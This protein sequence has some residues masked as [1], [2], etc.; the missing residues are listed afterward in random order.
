MLQKISLREAESRAFKATYQDG[1]WDIYLGLMFL[2]LPL[3]AFLESRGFYRSFEFMGEPLARM[4]L[5][6]A[7]LLVV[8]GLFYGGKNFITAPRIGSVKFGAQR[9]RKARQLRLVLAISA[10]LTAVMVVATRYRLITWFAG[11]PV[12]LLLFSLQLLVIFGLMAYYKDYARLY[13][14]SVLLAIS[15]P[16]G[17]MLHNLGVLPNEMY[18]FFLSAGVMVLVGAVLFVR[19]L[20]QYPMPPE[21]EFMPAK[22]NKPEE[23]L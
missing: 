20:K 12:V 11:M 9:K 3:W 5:L 23:A 22:K 16:A 17:F 18:F 1:I 7:Y 8:M 19:F 13:V 21:R 2:N 4:S 10:A 14:Y 6:I 15:F